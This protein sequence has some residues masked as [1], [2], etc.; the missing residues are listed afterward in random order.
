M[1]QSFRPLLGRS[2]QGNRIADVCVSYRLVALSTSLQNTVDQAKD[3]CGSFRIGRFQ[4]AKNARH[5]LDTVMRNYRRQPAAVNVAIDLL[6]HLAPADPGIF[7]PVLNCWKNLMLSEKR[8]IRRSLVSLDAVLEKLDKIL[9]GDSVTTGILLQVVLDQKSITEAE[10]FIETQG[11]GEFNSHFYNQLLKARADRRDPPS[12]IEATLGIMQDRG[13]PKDNYTY[14]ILMHYWKDDAKQ[15]KA[16]LSAADEGVLDAT[17]WSQ[18]VQYETRRPHVEMEDVE[19]VILDRIL[20]KDPHQLGL[21]A[22]DVMD[23]YSRRFAT[24]PKT[25]ERA[26]AFLQKVRNHVS[27]AFEG[28]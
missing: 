6:H 1:L 10:T 21:S 4:D 28:K 2:L 22:R 9:P 18:W 13:V 7:N 23:A 11:N 25:V 12:Q 20:G 24:W 15:V 8:H 14:S 17:C 19:N 3:L 26:E 16:I 5:L 27:P